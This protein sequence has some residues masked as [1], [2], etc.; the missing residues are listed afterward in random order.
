MSFAFAVVGATGL[1]G[2]TMLKV[3]EE[4]NV[5]VAS[6]RLL[7]SPRSAGSHVDFRGSTLTVEELSPH[8]FDGID[9]ALFSAGADV[10]NHYAPIAA[11][12]GAVA[13]D[14][15]SAWRMDPRIPFVVPEVNA[16]AL[17]GHE[18]II[19]NPNC[20]TIQLV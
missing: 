2:R 5:P 20:S 16:H 9:Y 4:R 1:V 8:A 3:L 11:A 15:S 19:A 17:K 7:A 13:I 18:G 6:L 14:N 12:A 10:S